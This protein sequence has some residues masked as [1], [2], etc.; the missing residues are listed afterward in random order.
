MRTLAEL[1]NLAK[2]ANAEHASDV[3]K[4]AQEC[5]EAQEALN[6]AKEAASAAVSSGNQKEYAEAKKDEAFWN[7]RSSLIRKKQL[8]P[9]FTPE[10]HNAIID[11]VNAALRAENRPLYQHLWELIDE[12]NET[13]KQLNA[14]QHTAYRIGATLRSILPDNEKTGRSL[15]RWNDPMGGMEISH[16]I[17]KVFNPKIPSEAMN[18]LNQLCPRKR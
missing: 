9:H 13:I 18:M 12:W 16:S 17:S 3:N 7:E 15:A 11:D 10:Q 1:L 8:A 6:K 14:N 4:L 2:Q 5:K